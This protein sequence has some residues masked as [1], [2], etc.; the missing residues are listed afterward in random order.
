MYARLLKLL[1]DRIGFDLAERQIASTGFK[2]SPHKELIS[3][4]K[5]VQPVFLFRIFLGHFPKHQRVVG[6][7]PVRQSVRAGW[8]QRRIRIRTHGSDLLDEASEGIEAG[9]Q[10]GVLHRSV[11]QN[12]TLQDVVECGNIRGCR[13]VR[14][15]ERGDE[16]EYARNR[17]NSRHSGEL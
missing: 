4:D 6:I 10:R 14:A 3:A 13:I 17:K 11:I 5:T 15:E 9:L 1:P 12:I 8:K 7:Q 2:F 16:Q